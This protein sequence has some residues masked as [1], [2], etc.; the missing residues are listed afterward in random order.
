MAHCPALLAIVLPF[1]V[2]AAHM[3]ATTT[4]SSCYACPKQA[5]SSFPHHR[6]EPAVLEEVIKAG[7]SAAMDL[8]HRRDHLAKVLRLFGYQRMASAVPLLSDS[9]MLTMF[10]GPVTVFAV[11]DDAFEQA[12]CPAAGCPVRPLVLKQMATGSYPFSKLSS[13]PSL[14]LVTPA[15][16]FCMSTVTHLVYSLA[17]DNVTRVVCINSVEVTRPDLSA[18]PPPLASPPLPLAAAAASPSPT[19]TPPLRAR[20]PPIPLTP[21]SAPARAQPRRPAPPRRSDPICSAG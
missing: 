9:W 18:G 21:A 15:F 13:R 12:P 17:H 19:N 6:P 8:V 16:G 7:R 1:I 14:R 5:T 11:P 20:A 2:V 10:P 3:I 4:F